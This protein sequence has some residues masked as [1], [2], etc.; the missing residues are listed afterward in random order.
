MRIIR[1]SDEVSVMEMEQRDSVVGTF[2][3]NNQDWERFFKPPLEVGVGDFKVVQ[4]RIHMA[5][6]RIGF[7][8]RVFSLE[9]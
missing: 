5:L 6:L 2:E 1:S 8:K 4:N 3:C 9:R 7:R